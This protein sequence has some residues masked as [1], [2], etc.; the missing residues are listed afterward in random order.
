MIKRLAV[1]L[2]LFAGVAFSQ[3]YQCPQSQASGDCDGCTE[4]SGPMPYGASMDVTVYECLGDPTENCEPCC[5]NCDL[6]FTPGGGTINYSSTYIKVGGNPAVY[7]QS[8]SLGIAEIVNLDCDRTS[9]KTTCVT[10][11]VAWGGG[12]TIYWSQ[13]CVKLT[14]GLCPE[15]PV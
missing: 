3:G 12:E 6:A 7:C 14:C 10:F 13:E 8:P 9:V 4:Y 1:S 11:V 15:I 2:F 5:W